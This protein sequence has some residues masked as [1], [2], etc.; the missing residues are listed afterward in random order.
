MEY[1]AEYYCAA[2]FHVTLLWMRQ[3]ME[4]PPGEIASL[5]DSIASDGFFNAVQKTINP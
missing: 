3:G 4:L 1:I 5:M 2:H